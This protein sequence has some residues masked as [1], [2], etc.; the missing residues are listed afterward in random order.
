[1]SVE[2]CRLFLLEELLTIVASPE[3][4]SEVRHTALAALVRR[5][6]SH[7]LREEEIALIADRTAPIAKQKDLPGEL[8]QVLVRLWG[9]VGP[10]MR[11]PGV[12]AALTT[13][14]KQVTEEASSTYG[15]VVRAVYRI[16]APEHR[17]FAEQAMK[18]AASKDMLHESTFFP[19]LG[20]IL[21]KKK[22]DQAKL[23]VKAVT[24]GLSARDRGAVK[25]VLASGRVAEFQSILSAILGKFGDTDVPQR[26][27]LLGWVLSCM[28]GAT[29]GEEGE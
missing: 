15:T 6:T 2:K 29:T 5:G 17:A 23:F 18:F 8:L 24:E 27:R 12:V 20:T 11:R 7:R 14:A 16:G 21:P 25:A 9:R 26:T 13:I 1:M 10:A 28:L 4:S 19:P 22:P 3:V